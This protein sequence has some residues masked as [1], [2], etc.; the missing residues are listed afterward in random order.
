RK[1]HQKTGRRVRKVILALVAFVQEAEVLFGA[2]EGVV[3]SPPHPVV[4]G[5]LGGAFAHDAGHGFEC[6]GEGLLA[7][8]PSRSASLLL[9]HRASLGRGFTVRVRTSHAFWR[10]SRSRRR[11]GRGPWP[12]RSRRRACRARSAT[13]RRRVY[14][15][16]NR[17][18]RR[19]PRS[20]GT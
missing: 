17:A 2:R 16:S 19:S 15:R 10:G 14:A 3:G 20:F 4:V 8:L 13:T 9:R 5:M 11:S 1:G 18:D 12:A 6:V 7:S